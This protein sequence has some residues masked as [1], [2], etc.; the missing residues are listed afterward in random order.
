MH[1]CDWQRDVKG[2]KGSKHGSKH[3]QN[4][5]NK[6]KYIFIMRCQ[7][8]SHTCWGQRKI[9]ETK[10]PSYLHIV[11]PFYSPWPNDA[12]ATVI[13]S[14]DSFEFLHLLFQHQMPLCS[15]E[16]RHFLICAIKNNLGQNISFEPHGKSDI[17]GLHQKIQI[18]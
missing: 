3:V 10:K 7:K 15:E 2:H 8:V 13:W 5:F 18:S 4:D 12:K 14:N 9:S 16:V 1:I 17:W 6:C 11:C